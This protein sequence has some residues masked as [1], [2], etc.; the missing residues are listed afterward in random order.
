MRLLPLWLALAFIGCGE[1]M[2]LP[3]G[4]LRFTSPA[5]GAIL[6]GEVTLLVEG[7]A[8][9]DRAGVVFWANDQ[10][11][12]RDDTGPFEA[13][14]DTAGLPEGEVHFRA[15]LASG[16]SPK[17]PSDTDPAQVR[18]IVDNRG[19]AITWIAPNP[20]ACQS[21][22]GK[23][24]LSVAIEDAVGV[25]TVEFRIASQK[26]ATLQRAPYTHTLDWASLNPLPAELKVTVAAENQRKRISNQ[27]QTIR[28]CNQ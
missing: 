15:T 12:A 19:P 26:V 16:P 6:A 3:G 9:A 22:Q 5:D 24:D 21:A 8:D 4:S 1:G 7:D 2:L 14:V 13:V 27:T 18:V 23:L 20:D 10:L 28:I 17:P 11:L 25:A